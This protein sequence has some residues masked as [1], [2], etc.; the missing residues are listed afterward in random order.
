MRFYAFLVALFVCLHVGA[1]ALI[2]RQGS[3]PDVPADLSSVSYAAPG[4]GSKTAVDPTVVAARIAS[5]MATLA[6]VTRQIRTYSAT[7]GGELVPEIAAENGLKTMAGAWIG[8]D[9]A[10]NDREIASIIDI[11]KRN[12]SVTSLVVGNEVIF[13][14]DQTVD[15]LI[16]KIRRVK[17]QTQLPVTTGEIW[18]V[19]I[20]HPE[21]AS[22]VDYIAAHILPYWEGFAPSEAV[23]HALAIYERLRAAYPGKRI[24]I[25]E[26]GWP[27]AGYNLKAAVPGRLEQ[28]E[29]LRS[30]VSRAR[31]LGIEYNLIEAFDQPWKTN[32][33]SV[34]AYWGMYDADGRA[35]FDWAGTI[36]KPFF[37]QVAG[38]AVLIGFVLSLP[39]LALRDGTAMQAALLAT[40][41]HVTGLWLALVAAYWQGHYL[42]L[43]DIIVLSIGAV[44]LAPLIVIAM[45]RIEEIA[46]VAFG[47]A[48]RRLIEKRAA[49][50]LAAPTYMPKVSIHIPAYRE[51][52]EMLKRTLDSVAKLTYPNVECVVIINNTPEPHFWQPIEAHCKTLGDRFKFLNCE[53]VEGFKAGALRIALAHTAPDAEIIGILDADYTVAPSWLDDL[54]PSFADETVGL[55]QAP[56]EHRDPHRSPLHEAMNHEYAG[57]FDIGMVQRNEANAIVVHGTMCLIRREALAEAGNWSSDTICEDSDLGLSLM[58]NGWQLLYTRA[59]YGAGLLPDTYEAFRKQRHR[60]AYGGVQIAKKHWREFLPA[61]PRLTQLQKR[62]FVLGWLSWLGA[63]SLGVVMAVF[64]LISVPLIMLAWVAVPDRILTVPIV[65]S[66]AV[67]LLHFVS[68]YRVRCANIPARG[69]LGAM[70]AAMS[71]QWTVA[72]AVATG[73]VKDHLPFKVTAKGGKRRTGTPFAARWEALL[74]SLLMTA[75]VSLYVWNT[76]DIRELDIFAA[77]LVLQALPFLSAVLLAA[78][79][80]S[81]F[82]SFAYWRLRQTQLDRLMARWHL[83]IRTRPVAARA[84]VTG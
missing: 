54:V 73:L 61:A 41:A 32:E 38:L 12:S 56:Q 59:R 11:A 40:G 14:E 67:S 74:A 7:N 4:S 6:P 35:K 30:F 19:W 37:W 78:F 52:P 51:H 13:R 79:E 57:F 63:E 55:I 26:F 2:E 48:P 47:R 3:A 20:E 21:L 23:D 60:W 43:S 62:E 36:D 16:Q 22:A 18:H 28:A 69:L 49:S 50:K 66:F 64:N 72:S 46:A 17:H 10:A 44:L 82:N 77:V 71:V 8:R 80:G 65:A 53:K 68:L 76:N 29:I 42:A 27:S 83:P 84:R 9:E 15:A 24:V 81:T 5:D 25:A 70:I 58:E 1:W 31:A 33:G 75:A 34:G 45:G 39:I